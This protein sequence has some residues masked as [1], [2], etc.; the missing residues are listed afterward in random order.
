MTTGATLVFVFP[1][2][3]V[4]FSRPLAFLAGRCPSWPGKSALMPTA[5]AQQACQFP[6]ATETD[7]LIASQSAP[8]LS[9]CS[10]V[11]HQQSH[12]PA[13]HSSSS[14]WLL[15]PGFPTLN[16]QSR[17]C[18]HDLGR[19]THGRTVRPDTTLSSVHLQM[20]SQASC[21]KNLSLTTS[22]NPSPRKSR[23]LPS[24]SLACALLVLACLWLRA[25][26]ETTYRRE[27]FGVHFPPGSLILC[28]S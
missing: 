19:A 28:L 21:I 24:L 20:D 3:Y 7:F 12:S 15:L 1:P 9:R 25:E 26:R 22:F 5:I 2:L 18:I 10:A 23:C 17:L 13:S 4:A 8:P 11:F 27:C 16:V 6:R 14:G